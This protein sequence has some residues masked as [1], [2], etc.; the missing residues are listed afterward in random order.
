MYMYSSLLNILPTCMCILTFLQY[1]V[2]KCTYITCNNLLF[3]S[4]C[5][6]NSTQML[7]GKHTLHSSMPAWSL[8]TTANE[9]CGTKLIPSFGKTSQLPSLVAIPSS[10]S[11]FSSLANLQFS[12]V[13]P[14]PTHP[15]SHSTP[16]RVEATVTSRSTFAPVFHSSRPLEVS[17]F[18]LY[19]YCHIYYVT[20]INSV[21]F[22]IAGEMYLSCNLSAGTIR[23]CQW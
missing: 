9:L 23:Q 11:G 16:P 1:Y 8:N 10:T 13:L 5:M 4:C 7:P 17:L 19:Y 3:T 14:P 6:F 20:Y 12:A 22:S 18:E 15:S 21:S 2:L